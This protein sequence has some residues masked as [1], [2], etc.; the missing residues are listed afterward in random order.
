MAKGYD[1]K[2]NQGEIKEIQKK[3]EEKKS[4]SSSLEK[5][6]QELLDAMTDIQG[7]KLDE[8]TVETVK[9]AINAAL[10]ANSEKGQELSDEMNEDIKSMEEMKQDTMESMSD[11]QKQKESIQRKQKLLDKF[12]LGSSLENASKGLDVNMQEL[13]E[14]ND[15]VIKTMRES[16]A[17]AQKLSGY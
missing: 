2:K 7:A 17:I 8:K 16:M 10:D 13:S 14:I 12:G 3:L 5:H 11:A 1:V 6:K 4:E 15:E 9:E